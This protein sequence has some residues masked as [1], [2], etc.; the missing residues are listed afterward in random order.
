MAIEFNSISYNTKKE[1]LAI[2]DH[3][4]AITYNVAKGGASIAKDENGKKIIKAGTIYPAND[5]TAVGVVLN[6]YDVTNGD[7]NIAVVIHGFIRTDKIPDKPS[8]EAEKALT[9]IAFLPITRPIA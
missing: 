2:P 1:I 5:D 6:E 9:Q 3:Y 8:A 4:V 7:A